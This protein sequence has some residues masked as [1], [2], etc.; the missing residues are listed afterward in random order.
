VHVVP[1][2]PQFLGSF[3][4]LTHW[5]PQ[6][7]RSV[8]HAGLQLPLLTVLV[9][10]MPPVPPTA[11]EPAAPPVEV[12]EVPPV[13]VVSVEPPHPLANASASTATAALES[14]L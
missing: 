11:L 9:P 1:H 14:M 6:Q 8:L 2:V 5:L 4:K 13:P 7:A 10:E 12:P 3:C